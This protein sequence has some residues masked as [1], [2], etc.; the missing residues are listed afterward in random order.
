MGEKSPKRNGLRSPSNNL[1]F[2]VLDFMAKFCKRKTCQGQPPCGQSH[3]KSGPKWNQVTTVYPLALIE[4]GPVKGFG[5]PN[6][7]ILISC[8]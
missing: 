3:V 8:G 1:L 5:F 4:V 7:V 2:S 6:F